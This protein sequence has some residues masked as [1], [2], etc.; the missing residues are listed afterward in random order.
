[1]STV[2]ETASLERELAAI[3]GE[4]NVSHA[5][6]QTP[7]I[8]GVVP[9][10]SVAPASAEEAAAVLALANSREL[11]V[12]PAGGF[13]QQ[14]IG[15][16]PERVDILLRTQ[17]ISGIQTYDPGDLTI[18]INA[19][20]TFAGVQTALAE[21]K[22]WLPYDAANLDRATVGGCVATGAAGPLK[23]AFGGLRDFCIGVQ[24]V[25]AGGKVAKGGGMVVKNV[26]GYDLMKL[27]N[28]SFGTLGV[29][30]R[31]NFKVF[32]QPRQTRTFICNFGSLTEAIE[33]RRRISQSPLQPICLEIISPGAAEYLCDPQPV[34]DPDHYVPEQPV[35]KPGATWQIVLRAAGSDNVLARYGRELGSAVARTLDSHTKEE[36]QFWGWVRHFEYNVLA[37]HQNAMVMYTHMPI[38]GVAPAIQAMEKAAPDYNFIPAVVGRAATGNLILAF[39][40]LSVDPPSAMQYANCVSAFRGMLPPGASAEVAHCPKEAKPHFDVWGTTLSDMGMM[41][42]LKKAID[43]KDILNRGRFIV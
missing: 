33:F 16:V 40:P 12:A 38:Q 30:T 24:F 36:D 41:K 25:T 18:S 22:Q 8:N 23:H 14:D 17:R 11:V 6:E 31:A 15:G 4:Q 13:T 29:I 19:G 35:A 20:T 27:I 5:G 26:A 7:A 34:K 43:P 37:R 21:H 42:A 10:I 28:G 9:A 39:M 3:A 32:P 2:T 1:M